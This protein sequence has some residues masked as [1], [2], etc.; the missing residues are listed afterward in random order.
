MFSQELIQ[1]MLYLSDRF[2]LFCIEKND[3]FWIENHVK[4]R[5]GIR[6]SNGL[7][8]ACPTKMTISDCFS[9]D[10]LLQ[11]DVFL[12]ENVSISK[13]CPPRDAKT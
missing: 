11:N 13:A 10:F 1:L 12:N 3:E 4:N 2:R 9:N 6:G 7:S 5:C 8:Q